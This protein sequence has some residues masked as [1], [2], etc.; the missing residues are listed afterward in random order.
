MSKALRMA[1]TLIRIMKRI[2]WVFIVL[3]VLC[4]WWSNYNMEYTKELRELNAQ[5][6]ALLIQCAIM[7]IICWGVKKIL[8][9]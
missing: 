4:M 9:A 6:V 1:H 7:L 8:D 2:T 3:V 5:G